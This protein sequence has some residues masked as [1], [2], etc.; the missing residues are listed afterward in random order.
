MLCHDLYKITTAPIHPNIPWLIVMGSMSDAQTRAG[1][2]ST[3]GPV[4]GVAGLA[5]GEKEEEG[6]SRQARKQDL[7]H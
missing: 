2:L 1:L 4:R 3:Q 7:Q 5:Q 6:P